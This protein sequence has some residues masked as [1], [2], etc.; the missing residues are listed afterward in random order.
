MARRLVACARY[1]SDPP[2]ERALTCCRLADDLWAI[3]V[4]GT[5]HRGTLTP[6]ASLP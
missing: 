4:P 2:P 5:P 3:Q 1:P 6:L